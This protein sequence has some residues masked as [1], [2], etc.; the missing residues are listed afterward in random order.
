M[1]IEAVAGILNVIGSNKAI[2]AAGPSPGKIPI[3]VPKKAPKKQKKR[4]SGD[5]A[6]ENP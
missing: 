6:T 1:I 2:E 4:F 5:K 3:R